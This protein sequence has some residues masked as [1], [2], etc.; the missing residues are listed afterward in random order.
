MNHALSESL[1]EMEVMRL[2][3]EVACRRKDPSYLVGGALRDAS[4]GR[5]LKDLD[6]ATRKPYA[7]A[8]EIAR[9][10]GS[11]VVSMGREEP[12]TYR[13]P[14]DG[15]TMDWAGLAGGTLESDLVRR[16]FTVNA[17]AM[18]VVTGELSDPHGGLSDLESRRLRMTSPTVFEEDPLRILKAYRMLAELD[19]FRLEP[20]TQEA[21]RAG[22]SGLGAVAEERI[23][24]E[25]ELLLVAP[26]PGRVVRAMAESG[27]LFSVLP[28]LKRM[29]GLVQNEY[30]HADALNHTLEVLEALDAPAGWIGDLGLPAFGRREW[31]VVRL[32][33]LFHDAGKAETR[34]EG[35]DGRIHFYGHQKHSADIARAALERLRFPGGIV[36]DVAELCLNHLRPLGLTKSRPGRTAYRRLVHS[37]GEIFP[38]LLALSYADKLGS[39]GSGHEDNLQNLARLIADV[40]K[41]ARTDGPELERLPK[42]IDGL[43]A[44]SILGLSRPGPLLGRALDALMDRQVAGEISTREQAIPFL[45]AWA[46]KHLGQR[47][48]G[49]ASGS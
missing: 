8:Q 6:F 39:R 41:I 9:R 40:L 44:L 19:G 48:T 35:E 2:V 13:I 7:V 29:E 4:L 11:R 26:R 22:R 32:A 28:P 27:I 43:E 33:A 1:R 25:I 5:T 17:M 30:H 10:L 37:M 46:E 38:L 3:S 15:G 47:S 16:D 36:R 42:L 18:D 20:R 12:L 34:S 45:E 21:M 49:S 14:H 23:E 24:H 31:F